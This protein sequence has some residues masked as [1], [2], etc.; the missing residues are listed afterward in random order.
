MPAAA[1]ALPN[2]RPYP[3]SRLGSW[4]KL[5][6][7][8]WGSSDGRTWITRSRGRYI[9]SRGVGG[10]HVRTI[11]TYATLQ[12]AKR[13][14][15][16]SF[17]TDNPIGGLAVAAIAGGLL[18]AGI[19]VAVVMSKP[20]PAKAPPGKIPAPPPPPVPAGATFTTPITDAATVRQYQ[21]VLASAVADPNW[22][23]PP[24]IFPATAVTGNPTDPA[25]TQAL[26]IVQNFIN[27]TDGGIDP[28]KVPAGFPIPIRSDGVFDYATAIVFANA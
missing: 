15:H 24:V 6:A 19:V 13:V 27:T 11:G 1:A 20:A 16:Y 23:G 7:H 9:L 12:M 4:R 25:W 3:A 14:G 17:A 8:T 22:A 21:Y 5:G 18:A 10:H 2:P 26:A 28:T